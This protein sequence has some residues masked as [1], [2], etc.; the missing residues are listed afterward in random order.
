MT[1][2]MYRSTDE[3]SGRDPRDPWPRIV[4]VSSYPP[5]MCGLATFT[6]SLRVAMAHNRGSV[7][8]LDVID[9]VDNPATLVG[10]ERPEVIEVLNPADP[11]S[12][13]KAAERL[14]PYDAV[15]LQHEYGIWGPEMGR[16]VLDFVERL[17]SPSITTLHTLLRNPTST[18]RLIIEGLADMSAGTVVLTPGARDLLLRQYSV[19][20]R[21]IEVIPHGTHHPPRPASPAFG[22]TRH[23]NPRLLTWGLI[24][25]G[26][27]LEWA[28][29]AV[30]LLA[31]HYPNIS[32]TIAGKTHPKVLAREGEA[33]RSSLEEMTSAL[34]I[35]DNV[36]F[37]D[38]YL[39]D[40]M[41]HALLHDSTIVV[42]PYD[43]TD[44]IV[45]GVLVEAVSANVPVVATAFPHAAELAIGG[46]VLTVPHRHPQVMAETITRLVD[47][48]A[49]LD[50]M[51]RAQLALTKDVEWGSVAARYE[52]LVHDATHSLAAISHAPTVS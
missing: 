22:T 41:L 36:R 2:E 24:G 34:G 37:M 38:N 30:A 25:P 7:A 26:K 39:S 40:E 45:S 29:Q 19:D 28:L 48:P 11:S 47:S 4:F 51:T 43:S 16:A 33:Y 14:S 12:L 9:L 32:Y 15:I 46:A 27:G 8:G 6:A 23:G 49:S 17:E 18:Q 1:L 10:P 3:R 44:Q 50:A 31:E 21:S 5:A 13:E 35:E 42:L 52:D 20:P